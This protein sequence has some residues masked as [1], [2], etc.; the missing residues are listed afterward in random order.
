MEK[1]VIMVRDAR[2]LTAALYTARPPQK[3]LVSTG[4]NQAAVDHHHHRG[5]LPWIPEGVDGY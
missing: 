2:R 1:V 4:N 5:E 3:T